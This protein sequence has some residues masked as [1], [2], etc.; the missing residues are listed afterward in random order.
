MIRIF[1]A[2]FGLPPPELPNGPNR[3]MIWSLCAIFVS[4]AT[5]ATLILNFFSL[6]AGV[7]IVF[8]GRPGVKFHFWTIFGS[9]PAIGLA[10]PVLLGFAI[11]H[12]F[13][14]A[15]VAWALAQMATIWAL[16]GAM[17]AV[18]AGWRALTSVS[19]R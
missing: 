15:E 4:V 8:L 1:Y 16:G 10:L 9:I 14:A 19:Q 7:T 11:W 18:C 13:S 5:V 3:T 12:E 2:T 17:I 6:F